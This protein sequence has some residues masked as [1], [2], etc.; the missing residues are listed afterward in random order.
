MVAAQRLLG[1]GIEELFNCCI[2]LD[3]QDE[4]T[5]HW[6]LNSVNKFNSKIQTL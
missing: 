3:L 4:K 1:N 5:G 6:L 2:V